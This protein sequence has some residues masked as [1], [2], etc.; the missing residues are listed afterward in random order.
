[1]QITPRISMLNFNRDLDTYI[2]ENTSG[3]ASYIGIKT[4]TFWLCMYYIICIICMSRWIPSF[5]TRQTATRRFRTELVRA[6]IDKWSRRKIRVESARILNSIPGY[7]DDVPA[8]AHYL[9]PGFVPGAIWI[10]RYG[11]R[12]P[13]FPT[14]RPSPSSP[15]PVSPKAVLWHPPPP[16]SSV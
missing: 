10:I 13:L 1:M 11:N 7:P 9:N 12:P 8:D 5:E 4:D 2:D 15:S 6:I 3:V 14:L 16:D